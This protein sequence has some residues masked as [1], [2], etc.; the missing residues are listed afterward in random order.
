MGTP[1]SEKSG[2]APTNRGSGRRDGGR[3]GAL[4]HKLAA[5][6]RARALS[7]VIQELRAA[8]FVS[9][10]AVARELNRRQVPTFRHGKRWYP[11]T[12][13]RL[14]VRLSKMKP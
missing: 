9:Y 7:A 8:G 3:R 14:V 12:V 6:L 10:N 2:P 1:S 5:N 4:A 13:S 11:T